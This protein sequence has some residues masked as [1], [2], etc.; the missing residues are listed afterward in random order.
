MCRSGTAIDIEG[1]P[2]GKI[3]VLLFQYKDQGSIWFWQCL[4]AQFS[5][6]GGGLSLQSGGVLQIRL[7]NSF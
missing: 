5:E 6:A 2:N 1:S 7:R 4:F 3:H